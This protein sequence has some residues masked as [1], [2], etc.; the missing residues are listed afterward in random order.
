MHTLKG[1]EKGRAV[2]PYMCNTSPV[3]V[4]ETSFL[5][6][7]DI[8]FQSLTGTRSPQRNRHSFFDV[9]TTPSL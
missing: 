2:A 8:D 9:M 3:R 1:I 4:R 5:S 6:D 7:E